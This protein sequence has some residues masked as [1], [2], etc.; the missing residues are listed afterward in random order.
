[1]KARALILLTLCGCAYYNGMYNANRLAHSAE[2]AEREGRTLEANGLWG[3]VAVKAESVVTRHPR[4]RWA[5][6]ALLLRGRALQRLGDC[7]AA[8]APLERLLGTS[9]DSRLIEEATYLLGRCHETLGDPAAAGEMFSRL[10][11]SS[12]HERRLEALYQRGRALRLE[13][14]YEEALVLLDQTAEPRAV[15]ERATALVGLRRLAESAP[16]IDS[17]IVQGDTTAPW[18]SLLSILGR[19]DPAA[20]SAL[21]DRLVALERA[22]PALKSRWL[23][24]DGIRLYAARPDRGAAR[25]DEAARVGAESKAGVEARLVSLELA[26]TKLEDE[27]RLGEVANRLL[28]LSELGGQASARAFQLLQVANRVKA[29]ADSATGVAPQGDL[30]LFLAAELAR[31]SLRAAKYAARL[32]H[33]TASLWPGSP[34]APKA[35]L[36]QALLDSLVADSLLLLVRERYPESP[37]LAILRGEDSP[38]YRQLEDSLRVFAASI[39]APARR[40]VVPAKPGAKDSLPSKRVEPL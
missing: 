38:S 6:D 37:Y 10:I 4:S 28:E 21:V 25:L 5:D 23:M 22:P 32:F 17:L 33:R 35:L 7:G 26:L 16:L 29:A 15:G 12:D 19:Q 27:A 24:N 2:K 18:D 34:Y 40:R 1:M 39:G 11:S 3:Q 13:G 9:S 30:R 8:Q 31:D 36:A 14:R 20:A